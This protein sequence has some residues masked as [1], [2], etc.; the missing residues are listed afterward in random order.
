MQK[1]EITVSKSELLHKLKAA[2]KVINPSN[3]VVPAHSNFLF[4]I[5]PELT[6]TGADSAGNITATVD[7]SYGE[8]A[9]KIIF[10][11]DAKTLLDGLREL[12]EQPLSIFYDTEKD[13]MEVFHTSG[14]YKIR[15]SAD[16]S[17]FATLKMDATVSTLV[18]MDTGQF[19][20]GIKSVHNFAGVDELRPMVTAIYIG[21]KN[22]N[23]TFCAT[24]SSS[25]AL[26]DKEASLDMPDFELALPQKAAKSLID[27]A[28]DGEVELE[29]GP[30][31][32]A[33]YFSDYKIIYR[34]IEGRYFN[35]RS[36]IP[37]NNN[38]KFTVSKDTICASLRRVSVFA[39]K[40]SS[41]IELV[42]SDNQ[43]KMTGKDIDFDQLAEEVV[44][45]S[46]NDSE[47]LSIGFKAGLLQ[48]C[49]E[50]IE[51]E[52]IVMSFSDPTRACL[53]RPDDVN[54]RQTILIMPMMINV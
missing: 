28:K 16:W 52:D 13:G 27:L 3:K 41:L 24:D 29:V 2:S 42:L 19:I 34:L 53:I 45:G 39:N 38:K 12:P 22:Y 37:T 18:K 9:D 33:F 36:I 17:G 40:N 11:A 23:L 5:G 48:K 1:L 6:V 15:T 14:K 46:F 49:L 26:L 32:V 47:S 44:T 35:F 50:A 43:L 51:T 10:M 54:I 21:C 31:N 30:K 8:P 7:C 4:E 25:M 20:D